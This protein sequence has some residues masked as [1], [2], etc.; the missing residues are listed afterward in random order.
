M[1]PQRQLDRQECYGDHR[2]DERETKVRK[3]PVMHS[4][5]PSV[6]SIHVGVGIRKCRNFNQNYRHC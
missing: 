1:W 2:L 3:H 6:S 5:K 4:A